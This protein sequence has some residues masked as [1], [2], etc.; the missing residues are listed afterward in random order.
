MP[1]LSLVYTNSDRI[2][3]G[4]LG[5]KLDEALTDLGVTVEREPFT[6]KRATNVL[7]YV[8]LP[9]HARR[10]FDGQ[11]TFMYTMWET[12]KLPSIFTDLIPSFSMLVVP[13]EENVELFSRYHDNVHYVPLAIDNNDWKFVPRIPDDRYFRFLISGS[14]DRKGCDLA[15]KAFHLAFP[16]PNSMD[17]I[18]I[19]MMKSVRP[20]EYT[21]EHIE[22]IVGKV[23]TER[24]IELYSMADCYLQPSRGEG[25]GLQPLQAIAQGIPTILTDAHGHRAFSHLGIPISAKPAPVEYNMLGFAEDQNWWEPDLNELVDQMRLVYGAPEIA[26]H[27]AELMSKRAHREFTW[28]RTAKGVLSAIGHDRISHP[29]TGKGVLREIDQPKYLVRVNRPYSMNAAG[30]V[31]T[32]EPGK[33]YYEIVDI[34]RMLFKSDILDPSCL[35]PDV[36]SGLTEEQIAELPHYNARNAYCPTCHRHYN[37]G[38]NMADDIVSGELPKDALRIGR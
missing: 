19:L 34:K 10:W 3:Y 28:A 22:T 37:T 16:D 12:D 15:Y 26:N 38:A 7:G 11:F 25:F 9:T 21:G 35:S 1:E 14:G 29:Y 4:R 27:T 23:P 8:T 36:D 17:R 31:L 30:E 32:F 2:G 33:D 20:M 13:S 18:P 6:L 5:V 24:E